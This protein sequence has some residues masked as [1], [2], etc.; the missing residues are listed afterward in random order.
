MIR[1]FI[2]GIKDGEHDIELSVPVEEI[3]EMLPEFSGQ[4]RIKGKLRKSNKR[5]TL[6]GTAECSANLVCDISLK[7]FSENITGDFEIAFL[8]DTKLLKNLKSNNTDE[9][10][11]KEKDVIHEDDKF[12]NITEIIREELLIN[13]PMKR[14]A[15]ELRGKDFEEL[16][17][18]Y[19]VHSLKKNKS[20]KD[21]PDERWAILKNIKLK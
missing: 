15:P 8:A 16:Y 17:P 21:E 3:P 4:I 18:Q 2:Q 13:L 11:N 12:L 5:Y 19:S 7:E 10:S 6:V 14:I 20:K 1:I 9:I